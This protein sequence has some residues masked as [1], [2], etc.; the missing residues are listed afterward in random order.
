M[1]TL[2]PALFLAFAPMAQ[3]DTTTPVTVVV[4]RHAEKADASRDPELSDL[5]QARALAL[6][7]ALV[8][9]QISAIIV[10]PYKRNAQTAA[11]VARRHGLT[12]IVIPIAG[13]VAAHAKAVAAEALRHAG[14]VLVVE[15]SNTVGAVVKALGGTATVGDL[16]ETAY[17][18]I[19]LVQPARGGS[20]LATTVRSRYGA[21]DPPGSDGCAGMTPH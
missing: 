8:D 9:A 5:G 21:A 18:W 20:G 11:A 1:L 3:A 6:D 12:P 4:V 10:T 15:H 13:G 14:T 19:F 16:C 2:V 7:S 17:Q